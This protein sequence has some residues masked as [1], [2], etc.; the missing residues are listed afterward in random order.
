VQR[1]DVLEYLDT[2]RGQPPVAS[3]QITVENRTYISIY[4]LL[5]WAGGHI[6]GVRIQ[7]TQHT[8]DEPRL[9]EGSGNI[10][11]PSGS[12]PCEYVWYDLQVLDLNNGG[13]TRDGVTG[14]VVGGTAF[15]QRQARGNSWWIFEDTPEQGYR[16]RQR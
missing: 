5:T 9:A 2:H 10:G 7:A 3:T 6:G 15:A 13:L 8:E 16:L 11:Y 14:R 4:A 1:A 12:I